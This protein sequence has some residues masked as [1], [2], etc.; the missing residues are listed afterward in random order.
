MSKVLIALSGGVDSSVVASILKNEG[1]EVEALCLKM[2]PLHSSAVEAA[3]R[4]ADNLGIKLNVLDGREL[5]DSVVVSDFISEYEN[6]RTPNPCIVCN[7]LVKFKLLYDFAK[8]NGF[9]Q[10]ATGH[11]AKI[12]EFE[13]KKYVAV[14][15]NLKKDQSYMLY[16]LPKE[17]LDMLL[18]PLGE[19]EDKSEVRKSAENEGL[20]SAKAPDSQEICFIEG[21]YAE[22][23]EKS[24]A[25]IKK[26][27]FI[28]PEGENLG[29][30]KGIIHYTIGQRKGLGVSYSCPVYV[31]K[32]DK[33]NGNVYLCRGGEE[34][35]G[36]VILNKLFFPYSLP[37]KKFETL[38]KVRY[39][40]KV[41]K[42][43]VEILENE[44]ARVTFSEPV[45]ACCPGQSVVFYK[46]GIVL[47]GGV[48]SENF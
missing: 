5:F 20:S 1:H 42:A 40:A 36:G 47:G 25:A 15:K 9:E 24:S 7:P 22:Y 6:G 27:S 8:E 23:L 29:A 12:E 18:F 31:K 2:S 35:F 32:I 33:E 4:V 19:F 30:H 16:R 28:G 34:Y 11:Y 41:T 37:E 46:D 45:R 38:V 43:F 14:A 3:Q 21:D 17:I 26:G 13:G 48:I 10:I 39:S 44:T